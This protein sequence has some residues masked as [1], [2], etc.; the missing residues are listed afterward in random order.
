M[1]AGVVGGPTR[2]RNST[3]PRARRYR[4]GTCGRG[5]AWHG[6]L[7]RA[8]RHFQPPPHAEP[9]RLSMRQILADLLVPPSPLSLPHF[10]SDHSAIAEEGDNNPADQVFQKPS[11]ARSKS[12]RVSEADDKDTASAGRGQLFSK[13]QTRSKVCARLLQ[14]TLWLHLGWIHGSALF[15][16]NAQTG[17]PLLCR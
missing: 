5:R 6:G 7:G 9:L 16:Q 1:R 17:V 8:Q 13:L 15:W 4:P 3:R 12:V 10:F 14:Q 11:P 2:R